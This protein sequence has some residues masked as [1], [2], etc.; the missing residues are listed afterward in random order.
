MRISSDAYAPGVTRK[1]VINAGGKAHL[2]FL[3]LAMLGLLAEF[4]I[5]SGTIFFT[6]MITVS[7][8]KFGPTRLLDILDSGQGF[9]SQAVNNALLVSSALM[10][11]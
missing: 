1:P 11:H 9:S 8:L 7:K 5:V 10:V 3:P 4:F 6:A 2:P